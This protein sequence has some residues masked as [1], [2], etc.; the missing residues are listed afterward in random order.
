MYAVDS[1]TRQWVEK[2][3]QAGQ[4]VVSNTAEDG[5]YAAGVRRM[6]ELLPTMMNEL[7][8]LAPDDQKVSISNRMN[9]VSRNNR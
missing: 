8:Q 6:T 3:R 1:V 9:H 5:T 4:N 7:I 2:A